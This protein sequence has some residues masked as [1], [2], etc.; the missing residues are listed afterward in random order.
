MRLKLCL[1][2]AFIA[3]YSWSQT[4]KTFNANGTFS[5]PNGVTSISV[6]AWGGGG[7]GGGASGA[8][9][10]FG[11]G[12]AG[13]GGGAFASTVLT[14]PSGANLN[15]VVAGSSSGT[16]GGNGTSGGNSTITGYES[17]FLAA[18]GSG[19]GANNAG[20]TPLGGGGGT[21]AA[22]AGT[23]KFAGSNGVNGNSW[24]LL[25]LLLSSGA[26]GNGA[27][28]GG[29]GGAS[30]PSLILGTAPG[31]AGS[32]PGGAGSGAINSALGGAHV[33]GT[34]GA[35]Q[36][37]ISYTCPVYN[38]AS[39]AATGVCAS[40]T[41]TSTV[42]VTSTAASLPVGNY[43]VTYNRSSPSAT[44]LTANL[45]I[46]TAGTGT[47]TAVGL[48]TIGS[49]TITVTKITSES[50]STTVNT[51][52]TLM[53]S[54]AT[55]GGAVTGG[56]TIAPG[57]TSSL[58]TL[59]G[60]TGSVVKWQ[61]S[62]S[63]F[64][65]WTDIANTNATYTSGALTATTQFRAIVQSGSCDVANS[66]PTTVTVENLVSIDLSPAAEN[67]CVD[68]KRQILTTIS[69]AGTTGA[70][71]TYSIVW[72]SSPAN[73][74]AP[75]IDSPLPSSPISLSF[76]GSTAFGTYTGTLTVK[77]AGGTVSS[78]SIFTVTIGERPSIST[79]GT[80]TSVT[81]NTIAQN[82]LLA[83]SSVGGNPT[84]YSIDWDTAAN[85]ALLTDQ[86]VTSFA[87][88]QGGGTINT[89][90]IPANVPA[91]SYS[92][93]LTIFNDGGCSVSIPVDIVVNSGA[94]PSINLDAVTNVCEYQPEAQYSAISY[95][96]TTGNP[97][98]YSIVWNS[99]PANNFAAATDEVLEVDAIPLIVPAG[100][101][102]GTY[103]GTITVKNANGDVS[104]GLAFDVVVN[105]APSIT[106]TGSVTAVNTS[107]VAQTSA[108]PYSAVS[109]SAAYYSINWDDNSVLVDQSYTPYNFGSASSIPVNIP[110]NIAPG[111]YSATLYIES[112]FCVGE[113]RISMQILPA[114]TPFRV[115][116]SSIS[117]TAQLNDDNSANAISI[118][119]FNKAV[120]VETPKQNIDKVFVYDLSGNLVY[121]KDSVK[122]P[123][124][125]IDNLKSSNQILI[126]KVILA[127][128]TTQTKKVIY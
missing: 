35:G 128:K 89:I 45:T 52:T 114:G 30:V 57:S 125:V 98:T 64:T 123:K 126:V 44:A 70:P 91:G 65:S 22:S 15:V 115:G 75:I 32:A 71:I 24:S 6:K 3:T 92:G 17:L 39:I 110:A 95:Q 56:T 82:A 42:T 10:L 120:H 13:G 27:N 72:D 74:F 105:A 69:Y 111:T 53:V 78:G 37:V 97:I 61:S 86:Q 11:R 59:S 31:N 63:P 41:S 7:S 109:S 101:A 29:A 83:Y 113:Y 58:L 104:S 26:G 122:N 2:F 47:F 16:A 88:S 12:A 118:A 20:G 46:S 124:L 9:L 121:K 87:F 50:C 23:V 34:G 100:T 54:P 25:S 68:P 106:T 84:K 48:T 103:S 73:T 36:V 62:V 96:G 112:E 18:G 93:T 55:I 66:E 40:T 60:H 79:T 85:T 4:T 94:G 119:S 28:S 107:T 33:G 117:Q 21:V 67:V 81:T 14:V 1:L 90:V 38:V 127:D 8:G 43:V 102:A 116:T 99:S 80:L 19:G 5:V 77:D 108:L 49:S 51:S 76:P